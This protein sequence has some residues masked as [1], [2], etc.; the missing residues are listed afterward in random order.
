MSLYTFALFIHV[1]GAIGIF[2]GLGTWVFGV[3]ALRRVQ[4]VEQVRILSAAIIASGS[5]VVGSIAIL[6]VAG[7]YMAVTA[8]GIKATWIIVATI[9]FI[10]LAPGGVLIL[11]PRVRAIAR[12]AR[13]APDGPLP[14]ELA[15]RTRDP[16]LGAGLGAYISCLFGI[17]FLMTNKPSLTA[18]IVVMALALAVGLASGLPLWL[19]ARRA[20][21]GTPA[22]A[23]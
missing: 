15:L 4:R 2:G 18:A 13:Q 8:W 17:V 14:E 19:A 10:L 7:F 22:D 3:A 6:G 20:R 23:R 1:S 12:Q 11:D 21:A 16:I 5:L 9:S